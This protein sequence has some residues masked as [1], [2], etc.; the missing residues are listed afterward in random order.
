[1]IA[2]RVF[3][4]TVAM[5]G[6][7][8]LLP[9]ILVIALAIKLDSSGPVFFLQERIGRNGRSFRI[10]KFRTM[11]DS[12]EHGGPLITVETDKRITPVGKFLRRYKLD[13]LPQLTNVLAGDMSLVGPRPEVPRYVA[14]YAP[15]VRTTVLSIRPGITDPAS[16]EFRRESEL[17][18][19]APDPEYEYIHTIL[20]LKLAYYERYVRERSFTGDLAIIAR[21]L[22]AILIDAA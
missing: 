20:P 13:E 18:A 16:I 6:L 10:F 4:I 8:L 11:V 5:L 12:I 2:K 15:D 9:T 22:H 14:C 1:V 17:L 19:A 21:T 3:D 7:T